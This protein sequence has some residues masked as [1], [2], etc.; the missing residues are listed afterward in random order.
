MWGSAELYE[1]FAKI[2]KVRKCSYDVHIPLI[3][4]SYI[5][6]LC[7]FAT[8]QFFPDMQ[9]CELELRFRGVGDFSPGK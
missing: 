8:I 1:Y 2:A 6:S 4:V 3:L 9:S 5:I 7:L